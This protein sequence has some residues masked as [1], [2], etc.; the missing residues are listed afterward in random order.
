MLAW[1]L[2]TAVCLSVCLSVT[3][4]C[5]IEV[6]GRI[7]LVFGMEAYF[8]QSYTVF[9]GKLCIYKIR[10]LPAGTFT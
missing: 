1:V 8:D 5:S 7:E 10:V 6:V 9:Y 4:R 3:S 2:P